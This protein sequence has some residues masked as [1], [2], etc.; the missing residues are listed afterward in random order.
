[1]ELTEL[2][3]LFPDRIDGVENPASGLGFLLLKSA[4]PGP[5]RQSERTGLEDF[6]ER[7]I[8]E[9]L[10]KSAQGVPLPAPGSPDRARLDAAVARQQGR[11]GLPQGARGDCGLIGE[12]ALRVSHAQTNLAPAVGLPLGG[13]RE[14]GDFSERARQIGLASGNP[15][16]AIYEQM[17]Q[18]AARMMGPGDNMSLG[19]ANNS[20]SF[21]PR[22][23][24]DRRFFEHEG[25]EQMRNR[26]EG[27]A[28]QR[29]QNAETLAVLKL[30][31]RMRLDPLYGVAV[32]KAARKAKKKGRRFEDVTE[33][34]I[35]KERQKLGGVFSTLADA[36]EEAQA[37][38]QPAAKS[39]FVKSL[40]SLILRS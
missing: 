24:T 32:E 17:C 31:E 23:P 28:A 4:A 18:D 11:G 7:V 34:E 30:R 13:S 37:Q 12:E 39:D 15:G 9:A 21:D 6:D 16:S 25:R 20:P 14:G 36:I 10:Q 35:Q 26:L 38:P 33:A 40:E 29:E 27:K 3:T 5:T 8:G 19:D 1:M 2:E 22:N